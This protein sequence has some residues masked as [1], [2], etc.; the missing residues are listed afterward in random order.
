MTF[1]PNNYYRKC[2]LEKYAP[3]RWDYIDSWQGCE[4]VWFENVPC[5]YN[6]TKLELKKLMDAIDD[7]SSDC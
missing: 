1:G 6:I 5:K 2:N 4:L 3:K 7:E